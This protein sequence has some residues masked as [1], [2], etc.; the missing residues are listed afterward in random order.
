MISSNNRSVMVSKSANVSI[1][2]KREGPG[3]GWG[4]SKARLCGRPPSSMVPHSGSAPKP[5]VGVTGGGS[6]P[7]TGVPRSGLSGRDSGCQGTLSQEAGW[8]QMGEAGGQPQA[9]GTD[10][11]IISLQGLHLSAA[12]WP[13]GTRRNQALRV[14]LCPQDSRPNPPAPGT[15]LSSQHSLETALPGHV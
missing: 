13:H 12:R 2:K 4:H 3:V 9:H 6:A 5:D 15:L 14:S 11:H 10:R 1:W 8:K 7:R